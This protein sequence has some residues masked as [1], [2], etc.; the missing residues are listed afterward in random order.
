MSKPYSR[1]DSTN[2]RRRK[3]FPHLQLDIP[4]TLTS[5]YLDDVN[6]QSDAQ[7]DMANNLSQLVIDIEDNT[8]ENST[9][10]TDANTTSDS[11]TVM[12]ENDS[13]P[14]TTIVSED[15]IPMRNTATQ[16]CSQITTPMRNIA[17]QTDDSEIATPNSPDTSM[18]TKDEVKEEVRCRIELATR[19][20]LAVQTWKG[21]LRVDIRRYSS[22]LFPTKKGISLTLSRWLILCGN[23]TEIDQALSA[24]GRGEKT[25]LMHHL[26]GHVY[27]TLSN[28]YPIVDIRQ[29]Y[30]TKED[31]LKPGRKGIAL[32]PYQ[33]RK[34]KDVMALL[35][36]SYLPELKTTV[37]CYASLDHSNQEGYLNCP[38]CRPN[39]YNTP[40]LPP[41]IRI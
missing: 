34:L 1:K 35:P 3:G 20:C 30:L 13:N 14:I 18:T 25:N 38:E 40:G 11:D 4:K 33:W 39:G 23:E 31:E 15:V 24:I 2:W 21:E 29:W 17:T 26:G 36:N 16:T 6:S 10:E 7:P 22:N 37:P 28:R 19:L 5:H 27:V 9:T 41:V 12:I 32:A 8:T